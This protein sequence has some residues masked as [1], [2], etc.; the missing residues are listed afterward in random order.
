MKT[1]ATQILAQR[2][3]EL[4][5]RLRRT[6]PLHSSDSDPALWFE[7]SGRHRASSH[8]GVAA[9]LELARATGLDQA[10]DSH[11]DLLKEHRPYSES[12]HI[13]ALAV[14]VLA[15]GQCPEHLRTLRQTPEFLDL[16]GLK[17]LPDATTA[18]DF[19]RR[20]ETEEHAKAFMQAVLFVTEQLLL[21]KLCDQERQTG[22][23][24]ADGM[25]ASTGAECRQGIE[26]S[27]LKK[28][29]G[30]HPLLISLANTGQP[31][32]IKN[33]PG[34]ETSSQGAAEYLDMAIE[35][36]L[37][38]FAVLLLR[39][40]TDF[41][42]T[43]HLDRW[44]ETGRVKFVFGYDACKNLVARAEELKA[45]DWRQLV[46]PA[47]YEVKTCP[48]TKPERIKPELVKARNFRTF[49]TVREDVAE[50]EYQPI[51]CK[52][53]YRMVVVRKLIEVTQGQLEL[54][55]ETRCFFYITNR[56][57]LSREEVVREANQRCNQENLIAQLAGQVHSLKA[58]SNTLFSNWA[59][60]LSAS[61]AWTLK[62]WFALFAPEPKERER[63]LGMEWRTFVWRFVSM[64]GQI[65]N[66]GRRR[67]VRLLGGHLPSLGTFLSITEEIRRLRLIR[68]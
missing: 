19:L 38:V 66:S 9:L 16:L 59:W 1:T 52:K 6:S 8:A 49:R 53:S 65:V 60:M 11:L 43:K 7:I 47:R 25:F 68:T 29:W 18:G 56:R 54:E 39:G 55:P 20:F 32:L 36:M 21:A 27:G 30:Y 24:D 41:S 2:K 46:R 28:D 23:I 42:Q 57:D 34:N 37:R 45:G 31:L 44:D 35:S 48:R 12:D 61:L 14:A 62:S 15:G 26:W 17:R 3:H 64:P 63:L 51:A 4:Q 13:L 67:V 22:R 58:T 10:L 5:F 40:D 50:F 33:R